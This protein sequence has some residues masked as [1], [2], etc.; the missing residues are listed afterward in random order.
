MWNRYYFYALVAFN[1][2]IIAALMF[3]FLYIIK[4]ELDVDTEQLL[5]IMKVR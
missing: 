2:L 4:S 3:L 1:L 5:A